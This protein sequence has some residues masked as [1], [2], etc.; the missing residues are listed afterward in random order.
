M[1][2]P[3]HAWGGA[4]VSRP[5]PPIK[6]GTIRIRSFR[7]DSSNTDTRLLDR[8]AW[9]SVARVDALKEVSAK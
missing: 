1:I 5:V 4:Q 9:I 6:V 3:K 7:S 2:C 8:V